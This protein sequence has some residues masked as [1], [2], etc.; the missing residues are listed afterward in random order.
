MISF[1][2]ARRQL[3]TEL[4]ILEQLPATM[5]LRI[6]DDDEDQDDDP[7][8]ELCTNNSNGTF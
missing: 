5:E 4:V 7:I 3:D 1:W 8:G 6:R 2:Y